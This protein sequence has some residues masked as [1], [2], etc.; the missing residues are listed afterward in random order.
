MVKY[1]AILILFPIT[2]HAQVADTFYIGID[3]AEEM[4]LF[5]DTIDIQSYIKSNICYPKAAFEEAVEDTVFVQL[6][7]NTD[8]TTSNHKVLNSTRDDLKLE[9]IRVAKMLVYEKPAT[10]R[11]KPVRIRS[12]VPIVFTI[13]NNTRTQKCRSVHKR[14]CSSNR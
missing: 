12:M 14:E 7:I 1:L 13:E 4:P 8:G 11:G 10:T 2:L 5:S 9:A 6:F 3:V